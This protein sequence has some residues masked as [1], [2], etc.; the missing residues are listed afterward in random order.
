MFVHLPYCFI[1]NFQRKSENAF[2]AFR[3]AFP[4]GRK[5]A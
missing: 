2:T 3:L 4:T 5:M 1:R